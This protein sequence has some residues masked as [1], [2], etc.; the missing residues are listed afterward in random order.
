MKYYRNILFT[1]LYIGLTLIVLS[2]LTT[3]A[4][5]QGD[6][7]SAGTGKWSNTSPVKSIWEV[8]QAG[9][10]TNWKIKSA[11]SLGGDSIKMRIPGYNATSW[12]NAVVPGCIYASYVAD[13]L[14][15]GEKDPTYGDNLDHVDMSKYSGNFWYRTEFIV[16]PTYKGRR[17]WLNFMGINKIS[18]IYLNNV[19]IGSLKGFRM[20]GKFDI[21]GGVNQ[22][23]TN[24]IA[25]LIHTIT[26]N[27]NDLEQPTYMPGAGWDWMPPVPAYL[28]GLTDKV[29]LSASDQVTIVDP[30]I[31][32]T[33][34]ASDYSSA[35]LAVSTQL[36]NNSDT[37]QT[38]VLTT[39][40]QP[41][42]ITVKSTISLNPRELKTVGGN[43]TMNNP[44]LW[45]PNGS[46]DPNLYH[47]H[48]V[49]TIN[50]KI[51]DSTGFNFGVRT[52]DYKN[53]QGA[54]N[55]YVNGKKVFIRGG[56]WGLSEWML[57]VHGKDYDP[58]IRFHKEMNFNMIRNWTG[59]ETDEEFYNYCDKYGIMLWDEFWQSGFFNGVLD[60]AAYMANVPE[61]LKR[62]RNHACIAVWCGVNEGLSFYDTAIE[63]SVKKYD[64]GQRLYQSTSNANNTSDNSQFGLIGQGG[65]S[66]D[67]PYNNLDLST[68]F[69]KTP[70][71][72]TGINKLNTYTGTYGFHPEWGA[73]CFPTSES[74]RQFMPPDKLWPE[75]S[76]WDYDHYFGYTSSSDNRGGGA[77]P[78]DYVNR[79]NARYGMA[80]GIEDFCRKA[81]LMNIETHKAMYE[82]YTD[83][84][85]NDASGLLM[86]MS[87]SAF[88]TMIWQ[89]YDYYLDCTGAYWGVKK[90][91]EPIHIQWN[92]ASGQVKVINT[93]NQD[94]NKVTATSAIYD[95]NGNIIPG[96]SNTATLT[97]A[98]NTATPCFNAIN[99]TNLALNKP[100]VASSADG[101][102]PASN[103][104]DGNS[105]TRWAVSGFGGS[106]DWI[107]VDLGATQ[108]VQAVTL[109]WQNAALSYQ[110]QV[111]DDASNWTT[112][113]STTAGKSGTEVINFSP[114]QARYVRMQGSQKSNVFGYSI[115]EF[116]VYNQPLPT[117]VYFIKLQLKDANGKLLSDNFYWNGS[118][119]DIS[120]LS[121]MPLV[122]L[123]QNYTTVNLPN[124][125]Q[126]ITLNVTNPA[127]S[128]GMAFAVHV[129]LLNPDGSRV[130]PVFMN[131]NYYSIMKGETKVFTIE[132][133]PALLKGGA[134]HLLVEQYGSRIPPPV[135]AV[136]FSS[137]DSTVRMNLNIVNGRLNYAVTYKNQT[138]I[139]PSLL[140][141]TLNGAAMNGIVS[142]DSVKQIS[143]N[144]TFPVLGAHSIAG[145]NYNG[146]Y[147]GMHTKSGRIFILQAK[148]FN[149]GVA[150][151]YMFPVS[152]TNTVNSD[153][154]AFTIPGGS[155]TWYQGDV[156]NYE[157]SFL[158]QA[159]ESLPAGQTFGPPFTI[160]LPN[161]TGYAAITEGGNTGFAGM[162]IKAMGN[163]V[164]QANLSG[165]STV[166]GTVYSPWHVI[167][168]GADLNTLVNCDIIA[169]VSPAPD[170]TLFPQG[171]NTSWV[172]P[173]Q[174]LWSWISKPN[175]LP[176]NDV[177]YT[178][179]LHYVHLASQMGITYNLLDQG[180]EKNFP[181]G[182]RTQWDVL[183]Q[184]ADSA[185]AL[186]V[187]LWVWKPWSPQGNPFFPD[188]GIVD[189]AARHTFFVQCA[190]AGVAGIK[191]DF[192]NGEPQATMAWQE[193]ALKDAAQLHLLIDFHGTVKPAG[194]SRTY[195]NELTREGI[196]GLEYQT[197]TSYP[198][199]NTTIPFTRFLAGYADY[200]P[201]SFRQDV[202]AGT[203]L[204]H[205]V[206]TLVA[207]TSPFMCMA[208][209]PDTLIKSPVLPMVQGMPA[210]WD[211]TRVL[212][213][214]E[215]GQLVIFARRKGTTWYLAVLNGPNAT[216]LS[217][218]LSFLGSGQYNTLLIQD[219]PSSVSKAVISQPSYGSGDSIN[220]S[221]RAGGGFVARFTAVH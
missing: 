89:T 166:N 24:V 121:N 66:S 162:R 113:Y 171:V 56:C 158:Q 36:K 220:A 134:P 161:G 130:L 177:T 105:G 92:I 164:L 210:S 186:N 68:Y 52:F 109:S 98:S 61:K 152:G 46:G 31:R 95:I 126:Q 32:T 37:A 33:S 80:T 119:N 191:I 73:A 205:Q 18:E 153:S 154:T 103:A 199:H 25:I 189:S 39:I 30:Y 207:F 145:N 21:T 100:V 81:Q 213:P 137:P 15:T 48:M 198:F 108:N 59:T 77:S 124:G 200:T 111:S 190:Q 45:W 87:Q 26:K 22:N 55:I 62:E 206:A 132:Y 6:F 142:I 47:C 10:S 40:I 106:N 93:S 123:Q 168:T 117:G 215:V 176:Q 184:L 118:S 128:A 69:N 167:E 23:G 82:G 99:F 212:P 63:D 110:I 211:E 49:Y 156:N 204:A 97:S 43:Y 185:R 50:G 175:F 84:L 221:L 1:V 28:R 120:A 129:Q 140:A 57:R 209:N 116:S 188:P 64:M 75:N 183:K 181:T 112:V 104:V 169:D 157:G 180:W 74:F 88:P 16:P 214:S 8:Y 4:Q 216:Q 34:L 65:I 20:R 70:A 71:S 195:P 127:N 150:F 160:K 163:R 148:V 192:F 19:R 11:D 141:M 41:G 29:Y 38:G 114:V 17:I 208:V 182:G 138:V 151:R 35:A 139:Q 144:T 201:F 94:Y 133:D 9:H 51:S 90:A 27:F 194:Q 96:S 218:N 219:D 13:S 107:Y 91:C 3:F 44:K 115:Y 170:S 86:W 173:G 197:S 101:N 172:Q 165:T 14:Q 122:K 136:G 196:R 187:K 179:M 125:N 178:N 7:R 72:G 135:T 155:T 202:I 67:G 85:W 42:N 193:A 146:G 79:I 54:L 5:K 2:P 53:S 217:L 131:D 12:L 143:A 102:F 174:A 76:V 78:G 203:T 58:R 60:Q 159:V 83:H 149:N 147:V